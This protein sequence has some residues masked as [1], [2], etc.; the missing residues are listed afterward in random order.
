MKKLLWI[1]DAGCDSGFA[2][3]THAILEETRKTYD[4]AVLGINYRGDPHDYPYPIFP[5]VPGGDILGYGRVKELVLRMVPDV[6]VIQLDPW[7]FRYFFGPLKGVPIPV[8]GIVAVDGKN[9]MGMALNVLSRAVFWTRF[10]E[11]EAIK[12]G[13]TIP[14]G[15]VPLGVDLARYRPGDR[16]KARHALQLPPDVVN[17]FIVG[18]VNRNQPRKRF[19][20]LIRYFGRWIREF[21]IKDA[22]LFLHSAPTGERGYDLEQLS[23]Y[24]GFGDRMILAE[25]T[26]YHGAS[27]EHLVAT[28]QAFDV[29]ATTT[30]GEGWGLT[31]MEGMA[32]GIPQILP[33][34][35]ALEEWAS[36]A[37]CMI[38]C[39]STAT[40][41]KV[42]VVGGVPEEATMIRTLDRLYRDHTYRQNLREAGLD[43]VA[44]PQYRWEEIGQRFTQEFDLARIAFQEKLACQPA[45]A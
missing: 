32:C 21:H 36:P 26:P 9:C 27:E 4:V 3:A 10:G 25:P 44:Q 15:V 19:D 2:K 30:Q 45:P 31:T 39:T 35:S 40:T 24:Y 7:L 34:W 17:G 16:T 18:N 13:M 37:A 28:Y 12:G 11:E 6:I 22:F 20:L 43:L 8:V 29:Q 5:A 23:R 14:S 38:P 42:N 33:A 41:L 1:G